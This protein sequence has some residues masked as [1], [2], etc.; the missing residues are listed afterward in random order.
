MAL[1]S[2]LWLN[3]LAG[4]FRVYYLILCRIDAV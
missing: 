3:Y 2:T 1:E 4:F